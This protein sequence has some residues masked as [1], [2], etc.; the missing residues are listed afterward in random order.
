[1]NKKLKLALLLFLLGFIGIL[2]AWSLYPSLTFL[3]VPIMNLL[4]AVAVGTTLYD[5]LNFK[6]PIFE[7]LIDRD[8]RIDTS[9][10]LPFGAIG[11]IISGVLITLIILAFTPI[12]PLEIATAQAGL[13]T[14]LV[15]RLLSAGI[16]LEILQ[17]FGLLTFITWLVFRGT[18]KLSPKVYWIA[19]VIS[20]LLLGSINIIPSTI[21]LGK[22]MASVLLY[23]MLL[24]AVSV[25]ILG[26]LYWK[27]GLESAMIAHIFAI[28]TMW[29]GENL[30]HI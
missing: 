19:I 24:S 26:W 2:S 23:K 10:I 28:I 16:T 25:T 3:A 6:L 22:P 11:G 17:R 12:L 9:G 1:M 21:I 4:V 13:K 7:G 27:K 20:V 5:K 15:T 8:K 29:L 18:G 30:F 14:N